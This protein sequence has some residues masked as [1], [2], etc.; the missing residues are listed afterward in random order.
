MLVSI[1]DRKREDYR[2]E[3]WHRYRLLSAGGWRIEAEKALFLLKNPAESADW[4]K[5]RL[6]RFR[7]K[8]IIGTI[9]SDYAA[10]VFQAPLE[11]MLAKPEAPAAPAPAPDAEGETPAPAQPS[12]PEV[13]EWYRG[14][15]K[16]PK[17]DGEG[18]FSDLMH[19]ALAAA[20]EVQEAWIAVELPE[21]PDDVTFASRAAQEQAGN[22]DARLVWIK[23][24][25]VID[26]GWDQWGLAWVMLKGEER[27]V[28]PL[29]PEPETRTIRW[30]F[31]DRKIVRRFALTLEKGK[32]PKPD[33][34]AP[35]LGAPVLHK[36]STANDNRGAV[37][38]VRMR[39]MP[40]LWMLDRIASVGMEELL[41]RNALGWYEELSCFPQLLFKG[42][43]F[44]QEDDAQQG[45]NKKRGTQYRW[46]VGEKEDLSWLE[47]S[48]GS[49]EHVATR[50]EALE[51]DIYKSV[52]Q[53]A[54]AQGSGA[55]SSVLARSGASKMRDAIAK[56]VLCELYAK[57]AKDYGLQ[58]L[59]LVT[60]AR[61]ESDLEWE[62]SG[63]DSFDI[64]DPEATVAWYAPAVALPHKSQTFRR[65]IDK[66]FARQ[67]LQ[68]AD[69]DTLDDIERE[70]DEA[71][72]PDPDALNA[73]RMEI[74]VEAARRDL[75]NPPEGE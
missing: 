37:P 53:M 13:P 1:L 27:A 73:E 75:E 2:P 72:Y 70:I 26:Y 56:M 29:Q 19:R 62:V 74:E 12:R 65:E 50:L 59:D 44:Q 5:E 45:K 18:T 67:L 16:N 23:P 3:I 8:N 61:G 4:F 64:V 47:P 57:A 39:L 21:T 36:L 38:L 46:E 52:V 30:T 49:L 63:C 41:K 31:I 34:D 40:E 22:L 69:T 25:T 32:E 66:R 24:E 71:D 7:Y 58:V 48:G 35:E 11:V 42:D 60:Q 15:L 43:A 20:L 6:R 9:V 68:G 10:S 17:G 54:M 51:A 55:S 33:D 28:E 14:M